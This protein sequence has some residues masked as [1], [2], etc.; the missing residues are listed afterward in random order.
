MSNDIQYPNPE[1]LNDLP[2]IL[3]L[4]QV[5]GEVDY[6]LNEGV[7]ISA[8]QKARIIWLCEQIQDMVA[9]MY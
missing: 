1:A 8:E 5:V 3:P 4:E 9:E 7:V 2:T 6:L